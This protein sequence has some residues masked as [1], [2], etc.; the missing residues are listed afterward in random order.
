MKKLRAFF[1]GLAN[2][3]RFSWIVVSSSLDYVFHIWL[4]GKSSS[5]TERAR[6]LQ[7]WSSR[8]LADLNIRVHRHG[9]PPADGMLVC[10]HLSYLD[11]VVLAAAQP[12]VFVAKSEVR[13]WPV[14]GRLAR[15]GGTLFVRRDRRAD[16]KKNNDALAAV[17]NAGVVLG[18]FPEGTSSNGRQVLPFHSSMFEPAVA[19][20]WRVSAAWIGYSLPGGA[21]EEAVCYWGDMTFLPHFLRL[22]ARE[23]IE[24]TV[25]YAS[26]L[27]PG[28]DRKEMARQLHRQV[29]ELAV[30]EQ[31]SVAAPEP[32]SP[33]FFRAE[34]LSPQL[35]VPVIRH[36]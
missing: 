8:T 2:F 12:M 28:L 1:R 6:W 21:V 16:V 19:S 3:G 33:P 27:P 9:V 10:N 7:Y 31:T 30:R 11:I 32:E 34:L 24:A 29:G 22:L 26:S 15:C 25:A 17:V 13:R 18:L 4:R 36:S 23:K 5:V 14:L 35:D 20:R